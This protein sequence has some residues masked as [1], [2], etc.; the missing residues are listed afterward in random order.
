MDKA[1][2]IFEKHW[3]KATGRPLDGIERYHMQYAI[4][5][6]QEALQM[7]LTQIEDKSI[8]DSDDFEFIL[9]EPTSRGVRMISLTIAVVCLAALLYYAI[10]E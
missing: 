4:D 1:T 9:D 7:D 3:L 5:A 2:E 6:V 10:K 8:G